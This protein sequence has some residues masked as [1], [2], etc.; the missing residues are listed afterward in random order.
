MKLVLLLL[1]F[2]ISV[3]LSRNGY[4]TLESDNEPQNA[5]KYVLHYDHPK[6]MENFKDFKEVECDEEICQRYQEEA[7]E[8]I[9]NNLTGDPDY[10]DA[11]D[12]YDPFVESDLDTYRCEEAKEGFYR[13][14]NC[15]NTLFYE[16]ERINTTDT[17]YIFHYDDEFQ[18]GFDLHDEDHTL[19]AN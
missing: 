8:E 17:D 4:P 18:L 6:H 9:K 10:V 3:T 7:E 19:T 5:L 13:C 1:A 16:K 2:L 12:E 15:T 14:K 11:T